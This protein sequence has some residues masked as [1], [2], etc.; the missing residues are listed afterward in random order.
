MGNTKKMEWSYQHAKNK[1]AKLEIYIQQ[2]Y[3]SKVKVK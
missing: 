3:S 1:P 2:K